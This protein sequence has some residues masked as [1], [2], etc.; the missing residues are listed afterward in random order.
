[1]QDNKQKGN[2]FLITHGDRIYGPDPGHTVPGIKK[3]QNLSIPIGVNMVVMGTGKRFREIYTAI[4]CQIPRA[5]LKY[6]AFCGSADGL[7]ENGQIVFADGTLVDDEDCL[8][9][10]RSKSFDAW[11]F[12]QE[13]IELGHGQDVL[14][15]AGGELMIALGLEHI[16]KKG[17]LYQLKPETKKGRMIQ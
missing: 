16:N 12:I 17:H 2:A 1:M 10:V 15:C 11:K 14:L 7:E 8:G 4:K 9:L 13:C 6:S 5:S 3:I